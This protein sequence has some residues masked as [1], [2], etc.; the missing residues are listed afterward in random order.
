ML[1]LTARDAKDHMVAGLEAGADDYLI[2]PIYEPEL[3]A[4]L[5]TGRRILALEHSL[6]VANEANRLLSI[7]DPL[8]RAFNRR[9]LM[10]Q[11]SRELERCRR[12]GYPLSVVMCDI[13]HFKTVNDVHGHG[14][15]DEIL[16]EFVRRMQA[17]LRSGSDWVAR[18][19]GEEFVIVLPATD[20]QGGAFVA[21]KIRALIANGP[22]SSEAGPVSVTASFGVASTGRSGP[23]LGVYAETFIAVADTCLYRSKRCGRNQVASL[24]MAADGHLSDAVLIPGA[25]QGDLI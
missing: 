18:Y 6:R 4:R 5:N 12:Y 24:E 9:Y 16:R 22:F 20:H 13:D 19:G 15:G 25:H 2:K 7:T 3:L 21:E 23:D 1:L 14:V 17:S 10:E 8:T 11:L